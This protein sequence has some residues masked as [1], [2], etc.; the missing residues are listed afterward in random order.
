VNP[1]A[2]KSVFYYK[3]EM[4][5]QSNDKVVVKKDLVAGL[6]DYHHDNS[7]SIPA[8]ILKLKVAKYFVNLPTWMDEVDIPQGITPSDLP[9]GECIMRLNEHR[10][11]N[12]GRV[13][14]VH[15]LETLS[16]FNNVVISPT[17]ILVKKE[18]GDEILNVRRGVILT[19]DDTEDSYMVSAAVTSS[20][21]ALEVVCTEKGISNLKWPA[22]NMMTTVDLKGVRKAL[23]CEEI[24]PT[25]N[26]DFMYKTMI[27]DKLL[28]VLAHARAGEKLP[29]YAINEDMSVDMTKLAIDRKKID[30][31]AKIEVKLV[32]VDKTKLKTVSKI[33]DAYLLWSRNNSA[34]GAETGK[35]SLTAS[36]FLFETTK[37]VAEKYRR[38]KD[39]MNLMTEGK[40]TILKTPSGNL[41]REEIRWLIANG[42]RILSPGE[43]H[44]LFEDKPG[45]YSYFNEKSQN[46]S[47]KILNF[48]SFITHDM[49]PV[50]NSD[51]VTF[52]NQNKVA[53]AIKAI[54]D[55]KGPVCAYMPL[56]TLLDNGNLNLMPSVDPASMLVLVTC[57]IGPGYPLVD[58]IRRCV[59][60]VF[61]RS[62]YLRT[63]SAWWQHDG[64]Q[65]FCRWSVPVVMPRLTTKAT[66]RIIPLNEFDCDIVEVEEDLNYKKMIAPEI[67]SS[68]VK[69]CLY[70]QYV[71]DIDLHNQDEVNQLLIDVISM[72]NIE[73]LDDSIP[74]PAITELLGL[75]SDP[76]ERMKMIRLV[77]DEVADCMMDQFN[78]HQARQDHDNIASEDSVDG[79]D[80]KSHSDDNSDGED[81]EEEKAP[82][83]PKLRPVKLEE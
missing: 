46:K 36:Y 4:K 23:E 39:I 48:L 81:Q 16:N 40:C 49:L 37:S 74:H 19:G 17:K 68:Q 77:R 76:I 64:M 11:D 54:I 41:R 82:D 6:L 50:V 29:N 34:R 65:N 32:N 25:A 35:G 31:K 43:N 2:K 57:G 63:R 66:K 69:N 52:G 28:N 75:E 78:R 60:G 1:T 53:A 13:H 79:D 14:P 18:E 56:N 5:K 83:I 71:N 58:H 55:S 15:T 8:M 21:V 73:F 20:L 47:F 59:S 42:V 3:F 70:I 44:G 80:D 12:A 61:C 22:D 24:S 9:P 7:D 45:I 72:N 62:S 26:R 30:K 51:S 27:E 33:D 10:R 67:R 38:V